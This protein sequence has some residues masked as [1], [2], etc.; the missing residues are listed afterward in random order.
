MRSS[1]CS[2]G[3]VRGRR[4]R[5]GNSVL[6]SRV[7]SGQ[8]WPVR[9]SPMPEFVRTG[10][11]P[12]SSRPRS[13][14]RTAT[15]GEKGFLGDMA[16]SRLVRHQLTRAGIG[17]FL[18]R[19]AGRR[20]SQHDGTALSCPASDAPRAPMAKAPAPQPSPQRGHSLLGGRESVGPH[21][22]S[23]QVF[24]GTVA[25]LVAALCFSTTGTSQ[26]LADVDG[27]PAA[28][29]LSRLV[30]GGALLA[31]WTLLTRSRGNEVVARPAGGPSVE[32][33][34]HV[35]SA[36][37]SLPIGILVVLGASGVLAYQPAFFAGTASNGVATGTV[38]A[39]GSAPIIAGL[40]DSAIYRRRP[41]LQWLVATG[42][43]LVGLSLVAGLASAQPRDPVGLA[44]SVLAGASYT[45]YAVAGKELIN[46][47]WLSRSAMGA[48]FGAAAAAALPML[49]ATSPRWLLTPSGLGLALWL[50]VVTTTLAYLSF[51]WGLQRLPFATVA[52]LTLAEPL[53]A[54]LLGALLLDERL[55]TLGVLGLGTLVAGL[56]VLGRARS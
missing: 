41:T 13:R 19:R 48:M 5:A 25:V 20:D 33:Q 27:S 6:A 21:R 53:C 23:P 46:R 9:A 12:L 36:L 43:A 14:S 45:C 37:A 10:P 7:P 56:A 54:A 35:S 28:V 2:R 1:A 11:Q 31:W 34:G 30:V 15:C 40:V 26:A 38:V 50:G 47:G 18:A 29:G 16:P 51:G 4:P 42:L 22:G 52:T 49:V 39:L 3:L 32:T 24:G 17:A 55:S 44:W 8:A